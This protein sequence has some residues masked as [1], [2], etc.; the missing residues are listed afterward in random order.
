MRVVVLVQARHA[1]VPVL[2]LAAGFCAGGSS[3]S[4]DRCLWLQLDS[5]VAAAAGSKVHSSNSQA[6]D[7]QGNVPLDT[8]VCVGLQ[9]VAARAAARLRA[10]E[11]LPLQQPQQ[12]GQQRAGAV[13]REQLVQLVVPGGSGQVGEQG[14]VNVSQA[15]QMPARGQMQVATGKQL[16]CVLGRWPQACLMQ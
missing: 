14:V 3:I 4:T 9:L 5:T 7:G 8:G 12:A 1:T 6:L 13:R 2:G 15:G 16:S 10:A 11:A